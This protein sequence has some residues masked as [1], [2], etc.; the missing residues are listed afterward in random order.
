M[1]IELNCNDT[2]KM[3]LQTLVFSDDNTSNCCNSSLVD[4]GGLIYTDT[5][6]IIYDINN[7][8]MTHKYILMVQCA[9]LSLSECVCYCYCIAYCLCTLFPLLFLLLLLF[10][11]C[12]SISQFSTHSL[13]IINN[14]LFIICNGQ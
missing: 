7:M 12:M 13:H 10:F 5:N 6:D 3:Y 1:N 2:Y 8:M 11:Y 4:N 14:V 9:V